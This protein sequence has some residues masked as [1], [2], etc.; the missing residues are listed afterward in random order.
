MRKWIEKCAAALLAS[1]LCAANG[2]LAFL[3]ART[4]FFRHNAA[5]SVETRCNE[6]GSVCGPVRPSCRASKAVLRM[7]VGTTKEPGN[8]THSTMQNTGKGS[9]WDCYQ[10][11]TR[12]IRG[13]YHGDE[14]SSDPLGRS[15]VNP[16][17]YRASTITFPSV[18]AIREATRLTVAKRGAGITY[19]LFGTP[20][21]F[22]L[23]EAFAMIEGADNALSVSSGAAAINAALFAFVNSGD[24]VLVSDGVYAHTRQLCGNFLKGKCNVSTTYFDPTCS[25]GELEALI[26]PNT[27]LVFL[28]SP[29]SNGFEL[30]DFP[31]L[32]ARA[33][34]HGLVVIADNTYG[35]TLFH[36]IA[37]GADVSINAATKYI[38]G[39]SDIM[40]GLIACTRE[41][42]P[43]L[44]RSVQM[45][46]C[47]AGPDD[48]Y[49]ALRGLRTLG[50]R[51]RQHG[52]GALQVA[53][54]L[55]KQPQVVRIM[56]PA[57]PSHPQHQIFLR[58][59]GGTNGLFALQLRDT[60][61]TAAVDAFCDSL[62]LFHKGFSW[63]GYESLILPTD[64]YRTVTPWKYGQ[65]YGATL[66]VHIG[67]MRACVCERVCVLVCR[68]VHESYIHAIND[69]FYI[70][71]P[72]MHA[73]RA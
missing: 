34:E 61:S 48:C 42:Y 66:R 46:A 25:P 70:H 2:N 7:A 20:T 26:E 64:V 57:L 40:L 53:E 4:Q 55:E 24:H 62:A 15:Y 23:E 8:Y 60:Y 17:V 6:V 37:L 56:H 11:D 63:G 41:A 14:W 31:S 28:E 67:G 30:H 50:V 43:P 71:R 38:G 35:P 45:L 21:A 73:C 54:W 33:K 51:L 72:C 52:L 13:G 1:L 44:R 27:K 69:R 16:P 59:F 47:P 22:A 18:D 32:A 19:G 29:S 65:G 39:H 9:L 58:D 49:M 68:H 3:P 10:P 12:L 5:L 36:P